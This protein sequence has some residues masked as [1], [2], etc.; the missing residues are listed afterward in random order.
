MIFAIDPGNIQSAYAVLDEH[1]TLAAFEKVKNE[2]L[3]Q[4][5]ADYGDG[6]KSGRKPQ[7]DFVIEMIDH[8]GKEMNAGKEVFDT[9]VWIGRFVQ[10]ALYSGFQTTQYVYPRDE[11]VNLCGSMTAK[12]ADI[13]RAL[14]DRFAQHDLKNGKGTKKNPDV[15]Y[16]VSADVWAAIAVGVTYHDMCKNKIPKKP[17]IC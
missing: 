8:Y 10:I 4:I 9:C 2:D 15:F 1:L 11:K 7:T 6:M 3:Q 14:I 17:V 12:D 5:I 13:R 16:G